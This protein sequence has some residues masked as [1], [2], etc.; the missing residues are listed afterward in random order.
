MAKYKKPDAVL[1]LLAYREELMRVENWAGVTDNMWPRSL[2][3]NILQ[4]LYGRL[5]KNYKTFCDN[6]LTDSYL[7]ALIDNM[8][9]MVWFK[10]LNGVHV[11]VNDK[12]CE[13]INKPREQIE[14]YDHCTI[15]N[16][17]P[18]EYKKGEF[19]CME[20]EDPVITQGK[21]FMFEE[22]VKLG[23][24]MHF[25]NTY[26]SPVFDKDHKV[27]GTV[28]YARD[29]TDLWN[30]ATELRLIMNYLPLALL[31]ADEKNKIKVVNTGFCELFETRPEAVEGKTA[32]T[33]EEA[34]QR[35]R[36]NIL[37][38]EETS[39]GLNITF[40]YR[41]NKG[42]NLTIA[43][44]RNMLYNSDGKVI[45][46]LYSFENL[47]AERQVAAANYKDAITDELTGVFNRRYYRTLVGVFVQ[48]GQK[49]TVAEMDCD[50]LKLVNDNY[51]HAMGDNY[52][53]TVVRTIKGHLVKGESLCRIGGDE[54]V[55]LSIK[56]N[57][58]EMGKML[59]TVNEELQKLKL[60]YP[61]GI[62]Y[63]TASME[64]VNFEEYRK[65]IHYADQQLYNMKRV[66]NIES[67]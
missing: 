52:L 12:F 3:K 6:K 4:G 45:G 32:D 42:D 5:L 61:R 23:D 7:H 41:N 31:I 60:P 15:W 40:T 58:E 49:F 19:V 26:K 62:S 16:I 2:N 20:T 29:I 51:G 63:G 22:K 34:D 37:K 9:E 1:I 21:S 25:L 36:I 57:E 50:R 10:D 28:G 54:F 17:K 27:I 39:T 66:K 43:A 35:K 55:L 56:K 33:W 30:E 67:E 44:H 59:A 65:C 18:E 48:R 53:Q 47:L 38:N 46:F 24:G 8:P 64:S 14:G 13:V 11:K